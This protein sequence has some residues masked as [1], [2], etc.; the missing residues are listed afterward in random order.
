MKPATE[1]D[2]L[3]ERSQVEFAFARFVRDLLCVHVDA[4]HVLRKR[5]QESKH[6]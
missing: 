2:E 5:L 1:C 6:I 4:H 3:L